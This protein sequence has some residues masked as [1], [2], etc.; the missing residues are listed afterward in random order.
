MLN[1]TNTEHQK[2]YKPFKI[3][4]TYGVCIDKYEICKGALY[5]RIKP[6]LYIMVTDFKQF[7]KKEFIYDIYIM[8]LRK[9]DGWHEY[10]LR[11]NN[12]MYNPIMDYISKYILFLLPKTVLHIFYLL[13]ASVLLHNQ[14]PDFHF[15][16]ILFL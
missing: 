15:Q 12:W 3:A 2:P 13:S 1:K 4:K 5:G 6:N 11:A 14:L 9:K 7:R 10:I 16:H 8:D